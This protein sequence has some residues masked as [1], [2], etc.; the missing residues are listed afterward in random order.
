MEQ[1]NQKL[2]QKEEALQEVTTDNQQ[3]LEEQ[4]AEIEKE[5][6]VKAELQK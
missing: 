5:K 3:K 2:E 6:Q 4:M 1:L